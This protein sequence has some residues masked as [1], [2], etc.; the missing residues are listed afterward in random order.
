MGLTVMHDKLKNKN[1]YLKQFMN[2]SVSDSIGKDP[3]AENQGDEWKSIKGFLEEV[4]FRLSL[5]RNIQRI[6]G[7]PSKLERD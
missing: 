7:A 6:K 4:R 5:R 2:K 1:L 3:Q